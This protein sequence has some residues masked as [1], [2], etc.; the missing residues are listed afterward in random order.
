MW[1][2]VIVTYPAHA[3]LEEAHMSRIRDAATSVEDVKSDV[4]LIAEI[5]IRSPCS[6]S[7]SFDCLENGIK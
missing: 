1:A 2:H 6:R 5:A 3:Q 4:E 7:Y